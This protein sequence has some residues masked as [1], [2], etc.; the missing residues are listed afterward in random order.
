MKKPDNIVFNYEENK[1]DA[2]K[3]EYPTNFN[4]KNFELQ[5]IKNLRIEAQ[6]VFKSRLIEIKEQYEE[7]VNE[8]RWNNII[9]EADCNFNPTIGNTY[10]LYEKY[11]KKFLSIIKP[12]EWNVNF[13]GAFRLKSNC[14]WEK[15][16]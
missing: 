1:Y 8:L 4:S 13:I 9:H 16:I 3:K 10:Y 2:Y 12:D 14:C 15:I 6:P 11:E 5:Q 7:L